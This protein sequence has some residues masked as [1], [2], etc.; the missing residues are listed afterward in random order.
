MGGFWERSEM[1]DVVFKKE[2]EYDENFCLFYE[3][4]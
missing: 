1:S 3:V 2:D 4:E